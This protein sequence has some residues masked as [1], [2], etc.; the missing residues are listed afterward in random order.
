MKKLFTLVFGTLSL[1]SLAQNNLPE[2]EITSIVNDEIS[3]TLTINYAL[4]DA[5]GDTC[6][7][8]LKSSVDGGVYFETLSEENISGD[9]GSN[10]S[11]SATRS[12]IWDYADLTVDIAGVKIRL[13]SSDNQTV[14][15]A[16]MVSQVDQAEL[17]ITLQDIEGERHYSAA[18][19]KL[20][21]VRTLI[22][23]A[24]TA[25]NLQTEVQDFVFSSTNMQNVLGRMPGAKDEALTIII[26]GH[27]D[28]VI[29]S[30][31]ADDNGSAVA[32]MLEALRILSQY[33]FE[34]SIR[35]IGFDAEELGLIG[36]Q[37][38]VNSGIESFE[39]LEGVLNLEMI[40][41]YSDDINSQTLP[42]GFGILFPAAAQAVIDEDYRGNFLFACGNT[43]SDPLLSAFIDATENYVPDLR[44]ITASVP[45]NGEI[46]P[47]LRRSDH[48]PFWDGGFQ[49]LMITDTSNFRNLNYHTPNDDI[50]TLD[51]EFMENVV[52]ATIATAA[53]LAVPISSDFDEADLS[54]LSTNH[55]DHSP[56]PAIFIY[57][58][59]SNGLV[60]LRVEDAS[61]GFKSRAEVYDLT[62]KRVHRE[63]VKFDAG[64]SDAKL[65]LQH[66]NA[67][68]YILNLNFENTSK[69]LSFVISD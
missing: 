3:Q 23:D 35:F 21:E 6:D 33:S 29:G 9:I 65:N 54:T 28:G 16:D 7:V 30:P 46:A 1:C 4:V 42:A 34:H 2:I 48:A 58:N 56:I 40:G 38:Y 12:L 32:G 45:G 36:S 51:F 17:L 55:H 24:F 69:S 37:N 49:A 31:A 22:N 20:N 50:S 67:G 68:T 53:E 62:G 59:P 19:A 10:I 5:D 44:L 26:D 47:D 14:D 63:I 60:S 18:P 25:A 41:Y 39:V 64:T 8:W 52:K 27:F 61:T 15:I 57:P 43:T 66:L 11:P 13:F